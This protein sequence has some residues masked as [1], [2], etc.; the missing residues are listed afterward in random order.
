MAVSLEE[1]PPFP[2]KRQPMAED[3]EDVK[4]C[5]AYQRRNRGPSNAPISV[6]SVI[7]S[8]YQTAQNATLTAEKTG[9]IVVKP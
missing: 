1:S 7:P 4:I 5:F 9:C 3:R 2:R 6:A 8:M